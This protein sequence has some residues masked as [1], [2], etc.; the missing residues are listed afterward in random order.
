[1]QHRSSDAFRGATEM[2]GQIAQSSD[3]T[4]RLSRYETPAANTEGIVEDFERRN[5]EDFAFAPRGGS[6]FPMSS[7][8]L[9]D[10]ME[11]S[12]EI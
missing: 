7:N 4:G 12:V 8:E 6:N 1:M 11:T 9:G 3:F 2:T 10:V 5:V